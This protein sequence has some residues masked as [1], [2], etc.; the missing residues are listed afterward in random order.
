MMNKA[1][2]CIE[3]AERSEICHAQCER[4][5]DW[6]KKLRAA[7]CAARDKNS[8]VRDANVRVIDACIKYRRKAL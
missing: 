2:P 6:A 1:C 3:C 4:Y 7:K 8:G 5:H